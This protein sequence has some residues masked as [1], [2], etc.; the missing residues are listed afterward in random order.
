M[1]TF[2]TIVCLANSRKLSGRCIA[3]KEFLQ[4]QVGAWFRPVSARPSEE[5]SEEER[6]FQ[7]GID[8]ALLDIIQIPIVE[9]R[10]KNYQSENHLIDHEY[11]WEKIGQIPLSQ[12]SNFADAPNILWDNDYSS[13]NGLHDRIPYTEACALPN[14]LYLIAATNIKIHVFAPG[15]DFGNSKRR[16]QAKFNYNHV[17]YHLWVTDPRIERQY[18]AQTDGEYSIG[19]YYI[20]IS[21]GE[22]LDGY[23]YKLVAAMFFQV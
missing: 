7:N 11:Y 15:A 9:A 5:I 13:Y 17:E 12:I 1:P 16:V 6:R 2:R 19:N 3:G 21:L 8:P 18:L 14:S 23:S 4:N 22:P 10:P 20:S